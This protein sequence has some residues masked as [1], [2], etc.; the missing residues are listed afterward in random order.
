MTKEEGIGGGGGGGERKE[1]GKKQ[2]YWHSKVS[3]VSISITLMNLQ[4]RMGQALV[5]SAHAMQIQGGTT[6]Y[7]RK[8]FLCSPQPL[9]GPNQAFCHL[10]QLPTVS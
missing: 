1:G 6:H 9:P 3:R 8:F 10:H 4:Q 2:L 7:V 5:H